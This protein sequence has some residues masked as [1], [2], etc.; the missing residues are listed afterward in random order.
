[1]FLSE[2]LRRNVTSVTAETASLGD[3]RKTDVK[4]SRPYVEYD[5]GKGWGECPTGGNF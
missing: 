5:L 3:A 4:R 2:H 1:M